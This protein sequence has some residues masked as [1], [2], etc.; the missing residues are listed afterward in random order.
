[1]QHNQLALTTVVKEEYKYRE[2]DRLPHGAHAVALDDGGR[3][4]SLQ[5]SPAANERTPAGECYDFMNKG[6]CAR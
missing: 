1:M 6:Y 4:E 5:C 2:Q 3:D